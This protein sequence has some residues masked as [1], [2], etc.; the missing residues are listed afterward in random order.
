MDIS[1]TDI[2]AE[3]GRDVKKIMKRVPGIRIDDAHA[4]P[5]A[6]AEAH[7]YATTRTSSAT[8][9]MSAWSRSAWAAIAGASPTHKAKYSA[10]PPS[11]MRVNL[12]EN[13][14]RYPL[15]MAKH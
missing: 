8:A 14:L 5:A 7:R 9:P 11:A 10:Q 6:L 1:A 15:Q 4:N 13:R 12:R 2:L 3:W